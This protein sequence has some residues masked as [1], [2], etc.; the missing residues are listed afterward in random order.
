MQDISIH[1]NGSYSFLDGDRYLFESRFSESAGVY[2]W[3]I[4]D[5]AHD[6]NY[7]HYVGETKRLAARHREHLTHFLGMNYCVLDPDLATRGVSKFAYPGMWRDRTSRAAANTLQRY[8][9]LSKMVLDY[10][11]IIDIYFAPM[12]GETKLRKH[13]EGCIAWNLRNNHPNSFTEFYYKDNHTGRSELSNQK[14]VISSD[15][16]ILGL[17][18][19]ITI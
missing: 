11:A 6:E 13:I 15:Q 18:A 10:V 4:K 2:L 17:D 12:D 19:E 14:L 5:T 7:I 8:R 9:E 16:P 1:F 3:V